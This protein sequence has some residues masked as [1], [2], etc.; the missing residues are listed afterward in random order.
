[1]QYTNSYGCLIVEKHIAKMF[2]FLMPCM[3]T[4][5]DAYKHNTC[6]YKLDARFGLLASSV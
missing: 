5:V 1:M 2:F 6:I 4:A 3:R